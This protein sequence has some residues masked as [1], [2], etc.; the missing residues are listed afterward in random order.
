MSM[1][2]ICDAP[3]CDRH[4]TPS[5]STWPPD[6]RKGT[7]SLRGVW[8]GWAVTP[9]GHHHCPNHTRKDDR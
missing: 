9:D 2:I 6:L 8:V 3:D 5:G 4:V 7:F 1:W